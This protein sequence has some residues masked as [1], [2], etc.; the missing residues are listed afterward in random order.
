MKYFLRTRTRSG[1]L[2]PGDSLG[3][4]PELLGNADSAIGAFPG[5]DGHG[6]QA[7]FIL[8]ERFAHNSI[9]RAA[10]NTKAAFETDFRIDFISHF[11]LLKV[12]DYSV[13]S[14]LD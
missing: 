10:V 1:V 12:K 14:C 3:R 5:V 7:E 11:K 9:F 6:R 4:A 13:F 2:C 8:L